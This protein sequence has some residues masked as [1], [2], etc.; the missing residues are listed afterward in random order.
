[1]YSNPNGV[2][3]VVYIVNITMSYRLTLL[4]VHMNTMGRMFIEGPQN[5]VA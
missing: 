4:Y 3:A 5:N 1:M 2:L